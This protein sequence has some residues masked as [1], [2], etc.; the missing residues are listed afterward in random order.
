MNPSCRQRAARL[1]RLFATLGLVALCQVSA[2]H[3]QERKATQRTWQTHVVRSGETLGSI[4]QRYRVTVGHLVEWNKLQNPD[5]IGAGTS[6]RVYAPDPG[7]A[8]P[9]VAPAA[10]TNKPKAAQPKTPE[11]RGANSNAAPTKARPP[12]TPRKPAAAPRRR[13]FGKRADHKTSLPDLASSRPAASMATPAKPLAPAVFE[14]VRFHT[15]PTR[16]LNP[17]SPLLSFAMAEERGPL[18][19][20]SEKSWWQRRR[21]KRKARRARRFAAKRQR[22]LAE[23]GIVSTGQDRYEAPEASMRRRRSSS[24][25]AR[26]TRPVPNPAPRGR[27]QSVGLPNKGRLKRG[28]RLKSTNW[29]TVRTPEESWGSSHT[30]NTLH[31]ALVRFRKNSNYKRELVVQDLSLKN[32]GRFP[33]HKSHQSGRDVDIRLCVNRHVPK[34]GVPRKIKQV[35]WDATW[36]MVH[37]LIK[38]GQVEY[39]FLN[40]DR[41]KHLYRAAKRAGVSKDKLARWIQYPTHS[42]SQRSGIV[43]HVKGH[44][45]H[46][47][48]R[49]HC[50]KHERHCKKR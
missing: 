1:R 36:V 26:R 43:R 8:K 7:Q 3:A 18:E 33:P 11:P 21:E 42:K 35:D 23:Q 44:S 19:D 32:G 31:Q 9:Q 29:Y 37:E 2:A 14:R 45:V 34:N 24:R 49:F 16:D 22:A 4:A 6:L 50:G 30:I 39:I 10:K 25:R 13:H 27:A 20:L 40:Y 15:I 17:R 48:V 46:I 5:Q 38:S 12:Q 28:I 47:H 41:Q